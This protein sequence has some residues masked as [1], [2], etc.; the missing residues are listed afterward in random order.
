MMGRFVS[1]AEW[2]S[3]CQTL[4]FTFEGEVV[5]YTF[6]VLKFGTPDISEQEALPEGV[7]QCFYSA[8][9]QIIDCWL[10]VW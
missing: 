10:K 7:G 6:S 9:Y 4:G 3:L 2:M 1:V 5:N 8:I